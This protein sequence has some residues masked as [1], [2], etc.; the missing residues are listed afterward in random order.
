MNELE[1]YVNG[2]FG[3][4]GTQVHDL[5]QLFASSS[6]KKGEFFSKQ[7]MPCGFLGFLRSGHLRVYASHE[8]KEVTQWISSPGDF[9]TDLESIIF[10]R[11]A[12]W[13]IQALSDCD[14]FMISSENYR[15]IDQYI[16]DWDKI[17]KTF[18]AKCFLT[19]EDRVFSFLALDSEERFNAFMKLKPELFNSVPLHYIASMLGMTP[20]TLSRIRRKMIS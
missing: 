3:I 7:G 12:K 20:E 14:L 16:S 4:T 2:Y 13:N 17:E 10:K 15:N 8:D 6:L 11:P 5:T 1:Q 9:V 18:L 19:L